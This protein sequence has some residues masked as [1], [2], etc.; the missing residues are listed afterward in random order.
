MSVVDTHIT[1]GN[2]EIVKIIDSKA[3]H[4]WYM[5]ISNCNASAAG[6]TWAAQYSIHATNP[7]GRFSAEFGIN[8]QQ[9]LGLYLTFTFFFYLPLLAVHAYG[10][11]KLRAVDAITM[12]VKAITAYLVLQFVASLFIFV[13]WAV[14]ANDGFGINTLNRFGDVLQALAEILL[15]VLLL[16]MSQGWG[17]SSLTFRDP[18]AIKAAAVAVTLAYLVL[19]FWRIAGESPE[20][21]LYYYESVAGGLALALRCLLCI[22][23]VVS[24]RLTFREESN[25][26]T[27]N[28]YTMFGSLYGFWFLV[29]VFIVLIGA[30]VPPVYRERTVEVM[31]V[32]QAFAAGAVLAVCFSPWASGRLFDI[33]GQKSAYLAIG[34]ERQPLKPSFR[35]IETQKE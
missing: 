8:E 11:V 26:K 29:L 22:Y 7:G 30:A 3:P 20:S 4:F 1:Y 34:D 13:H 5:A 19:L 24:L 2:T 6:K 23:F 10:V 12:V 28:F 25:P 21:T 27:R 15:T 35:P 17:I 33:G 31:T 9:L 32:M 14:F 16:A 18:N